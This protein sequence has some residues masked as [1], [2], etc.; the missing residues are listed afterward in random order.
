MNGLQYED[1]EVQV[2]E[3]G[4]LTSYCSIVVFW[5]ETIVGSTLI[6]GI[7][8]VDSMFVATAVVL[9]TS[10]SQFPITEESANKNQKIIFNS[11]HMCLAIFVS[12]LNHVFTDHY[13]Q[14]KF[15]IIF[16]CST[17]EPIPKSQ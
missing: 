8:M 16:F 13:L 2:I 4:I 12:I 6:S 10:E 14:F 5:V 9:W 15:D 11:L 1:I 17:N 7:L 3:N